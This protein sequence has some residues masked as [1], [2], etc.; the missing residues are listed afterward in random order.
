MTDFSKKEGKLKIKI[1]VLVG[2]ALFIFGFFY[3]SKSVFA[4]DIV[5]KSGRIVKGSITEQTDEYVKIDFQGVN[6][7]YWKDDIKE[8]RPDAA[9]LP[10][11]MTPSRFH[12]PVFEPSPV[13]ESKSLL[14][15]QNPSKGKKSFFWKVAS[16]NADMYVLGSIHMAKA[17]L[18]PLDKKIEDAFASS[19]ILAVEANINQMDFLSNLSFMESGIYLPPETL[20]RHISKK[21]YRLVKKKVARIGMDMNQL[22]MYKPWFLAMQLLGLELISLGFDPGQGIDMH[23]LKRAQ[24]NMRI[25]ELEGLAYQMDLLDG[26]TDNEQEGF[27]VS[28]LADLDILETKMDQLFSI[29]KSGDVA[30]LEAMIQ[31]ASS[32]PQMASFYRKVLYK[33]NRLMVKKLDGFLRRGGDYFI[34]VG[35]AHLVGSE[36]MIQL[37]RKKGYSVSQL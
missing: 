28:T 29:W 26:L 1:G 19:D 22:N 5:L 18:Y 10:V 31:E 27:L 34:V 15:V 30:G 23:F 37:L 36:G 20:D 12:L 21:T 11:S 14:S 7:T 8:I 2:V 4:D 32:Y 3:F 35:T 33:R 25:I 9:N 24:G 17:N 13:T 16:A 6:L